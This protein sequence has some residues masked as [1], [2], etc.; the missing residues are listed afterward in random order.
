MSTHKK[1]I[2]TSVANK[3]S[4]AKTIAEWT[5]KDWNKMYKNLDLDEKELYDSTERGEWSTTENLKEEIELGRIAAENYFKKDTMVSLRMS[6]ETQKRLKHI[7]VEAGI[8][9]QSLI[10]N[11]LNRYSL[12]LLKDFKRKT[13]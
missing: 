6:T 3:P 4:N 12:G 1:Y 7:A 9:Y 11:V 2:K 5:N 13:G 10:S 8:P